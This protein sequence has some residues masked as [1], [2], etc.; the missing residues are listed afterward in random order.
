M[1]IKCL[2][3]FR[4]K[5][6]QIKKSRNVSAKPT[7]NKKKLW[8]LQQTAGIKKAGQQGLFIPLRG[9]GRNRTCI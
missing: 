6:G 1:Q 5:K 4:Q 7:S 2:H 9:S 3:K 8:K